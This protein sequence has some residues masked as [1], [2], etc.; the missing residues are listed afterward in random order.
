MTKI[1]YITGDATEPVGDGRKF[2]IHVCN[3]VGGWGS[4]FVVALSKKWKQPEAAYRKWY[5]EKVYMFQGK[6]NDFVLGNIQPVKVEDGMVVINMIG[7]RDIRVNKGVPPIRYDAI[8]QC[9]EKVVLLAKQYGV[10]V[11][12]PRFGAGLAGGDWDQIEKLIQET[13]CQSDIPVT[14]YDLPETSLVI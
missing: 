4:G 2:I 11:H 8:K 5:K 10:S 13:L 7:Q 3:D 12:A 9:L 1:Q 14:I 6:P